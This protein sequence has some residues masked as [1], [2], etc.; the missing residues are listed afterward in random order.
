VHDWLL[1][2]ERIIWRDPESGDA[3]AC[4]VERGLV[5]TRANA[6]P[7]SWT[8]LQTAGPEVLS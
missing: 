4:A 8:K 5:Q 2:M 7:N 1:E 6:V 3:S